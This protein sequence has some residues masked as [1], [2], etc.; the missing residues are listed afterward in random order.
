[1]YARAANLAPDH[2]ACTDCHRDPHLGQTAQIRRADGQTGCVSCHQETSWREPAFDHAPTGFVLENRHAAVQCN[3]CHKPTRRS[4]QV[5]L[6]FQG[7]AKHCAG[8]HDDVHG[9]EFAAR[10]TPDGSAV[11]CAGCHVTVD[12]FAEKFDHETDSRFPLRGGHENVACRTCHIPRLQ[13]DQRLVHFKPLP[14]DCR[15]C[16]GNAPDSGQGLNEGKS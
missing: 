6:A 13:D 2:E 10:K 11:D 3:A 15:G 4:G 14:V 5:E 12:W 8:C 1:V 16:H 9:G 7:A